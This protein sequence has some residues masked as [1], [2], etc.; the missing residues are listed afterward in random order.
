MDLGRA[1]P[2]AHGW[3]RLPFEAIE[4]IV[5]HLDGLPDRHSL[6]A[7]AATRLVGRH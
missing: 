2:A 7:L 5:G 6:T 1:E 4:N 3:E